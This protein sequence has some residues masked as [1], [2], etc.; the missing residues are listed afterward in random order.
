MSTKSNYIRIPI[1]EGIVESNQLEQHNTN[2]QAHRGEISQHHLESLKKITYN[3]LDLHGIGYHIKHDPRYKLLPPGACQTIRKYWIAWRRKRGSKHIPKHTVVSSWRANQ[4]NLIRI[5]IN[6]QLTYS[7]TNTLKCLLANTQSIK[8]KDAVLHQFILENDRDIC[9]VTETW[10]S[11]SDIDQVWIQATD[12]NKNGLMMYT[13]NTEGKRGGGVALIVCDNIKVKLID[14]KNCRTFQYAKWLLTTSHSEFTYTI[15]Y[16]PPYTNSSKLTN[17]DFLDEFTE[18]STH[19]LANN[20]NLVLLGDFNIHI[21]EEND[22]DANN[23][24]DT[25]EALGMIKHVKF[26]MHKANHTIDHIYTKLFSDIKATGCEKG[27]LI[28]DHHIIVFNTSIPKLKLTTTAISYRKLKKVNPTDLAQKRSLNATYPDL[29]I[30]IEALKDQLSK[31]LDELE[32]PRTKRLNTRQ[33]VPWF[34]D[35]IID[36]KRTMRRKEKKWKKYRRDDQW[37]AFTIER[38]K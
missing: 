9:C 16:H 1:L 26:S 12:L 35:H 22:N 25:M 29:N 10:L 11:S 21:D 31:A 23:F 15:L 20:N 13:S 36:L 4:D 2:Q 27:D 24:R 6:E 3:R 17:Q 33:T 34:I 28:S 8:N 38:N 18:W 7:Q 37:K 14:D 32:P 5:T 30:R 19:M